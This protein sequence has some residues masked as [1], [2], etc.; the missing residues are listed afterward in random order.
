MNSTFM[1]LSIAVRGL[2]SS[3]AALAVTTNNI[4]NVNTE[5]YTRQTVNQSA[6]TPAAVYNSSA[7]IGSGSQVNS[8]DQ[9]RDTQLDKKY[10]R[11]NA[12]VGEWDTKA[13]G[14][15][16]LETILGDTSDN[17]LSAVL[18]DFYSAL[19]DLSS[20][21]SSSSARTVVKQTGNAVCEYLNSTAQQLTDLRADVNTDIK[22]GVSSLNAYAQQIA[23]LNQQIQTAAATGASVNDL[24][25]QRNLLIDQLSN[26]A[27]IE[28]NEVTIGTR[29]DGTNNT[30][31]SITV[32]GAALVTGSK[33]RQLEIYEIHDS[34]SQEG[35]Y[36]IR[37]QDSGDDF[38]PGGG[39]LKA[40]F[41]LRDGTGSDSE[42]KGI[43]YYMNQLNEFA[44]TF[45]RAFNEGIGDVSGHADG[46]GSDGSTDIRFFS[47]NDLSSE[48][49]MSSGADIDSIYA[50]ITAANLSLSWDVQE[51]VG[52]IAAASASG[53][54]GNNENIQALISLCAN[55]SMFNTGTP[56]DFINSIVS[57][58]GSDSSYAQRQA[59]SHNTILTHLTNR[60]SSVSGVSTN[61]ETAN[62]TKYQQAYEASAAMVN[63]WDEIYKET[64]N[65]VSD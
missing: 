55:T 27:S 6:V 45:A 42:Y 14:L 46:T 19:E 21:P 8:V 48:D 40:S 63:V 4:S 60:R 62:L 12:T 30:I 7:I 17:G 53:E 29:P 59:D 51:D 23:D 31:V 26:L 13:A 15:T 16:Q 56:D 25:D 41:D 1:G 20:D 47:Y 50:N 35:L 18:E 52:K 64:I 11:E 24:M 65:L 22:T 61:E 37:W 43:P 57:T 44:Q 38:S 5:G 33:A 3:Q 28:V 58:L 2:Y 34:S 39:S 36:G 9:I 49:F 54:A 10:W 32:N